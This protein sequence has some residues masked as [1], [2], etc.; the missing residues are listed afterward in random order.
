MTLPSLVLVHWAAPPT[1]ATP[2]ISPAVP[3]SVALADPSALTSCSV[4]CA[5][6]KVSTT[7]ASL[8]LTFSA[9]PAN[10]PMKGMRARMPSSP[11]PA[12]CSEKTKVG[13]STYCASSTLP[14]GFTVVSLRVRPDS[15]NSN[16][17]FVPLRPRLRSTTRKQPLCCSIMRTSG[18][19]ELGS[20]PLLL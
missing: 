18:T 9:K 3:R 20:P 1:P 4:V 7:W 17:C 2:S 14:R 13:V 11:P 12:F 6:V 16:S 10:C 5:S 8:N 15:A 19:G